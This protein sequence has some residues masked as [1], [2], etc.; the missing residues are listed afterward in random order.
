MHALALLLVTTAGMPQ[1]PPRPVPQDLEALATRVDAAHHPQGP[2]PPVNALK[3]RLELHV[4]DTEAPQGGQVDLEVIYLEW[5][6]PGSTQPRPLIRYE[7]L[8]AGSPIVRGRDRNGPW[9]LFQGEP[10]DL[11]GAEFVAADLAA[12]D[13]HTNLARQLVKFL[14]PGAVLRALEQPAPVREEELRID[15]GT[16]VVCE[17]VEG[18]LPAFPLLQ[19][20]GEDAAVQLKIFVTK[21]NGR[22]LA[23]EASPLADGKPDPA[24]LERVNLLDLHESSGLLVPRKIEHL[25]RGADGR[26]RP[27]SRAVLTTLALRPEFDVGDFDRPK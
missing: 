13:R 16:K 3:S 1:D 25:F 9:Q 15:R 8:E 6:R 23:V 14:D 20:G 4:L 7:V 26:L 22:L 17:T 12:C 21:E 10:R 27:Q 19:Q 2:V 5:L 18:R 24:K 11:R